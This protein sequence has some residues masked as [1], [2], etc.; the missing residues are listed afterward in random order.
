[1]ETTSARIRAH[2][3][4]GVEREPSS[5]GRWTWDWQE[6]ALEHSR[7]DGAP[8]SV[9]AAGTKAPRREPAS[10]NPH[11]RVI[12]QRRWTHCMGPF[13]ASHRIMAFMAQRP[14]SLTGFLAS[15]RNDKT[16]EGAMPSLTTRV[17]W[18]IP[19]VC[20]R[21]ARQASVRRLSWT[22]PTGSKVTIR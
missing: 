18:S 6:T 8:P 1:M 3:C 21:S 19:S 16:R 2:R 10:F 17:S 12:R 15:G 4:G 5:R 9:C 7:H 20:Q 13:D 22:H 14:P 11:H